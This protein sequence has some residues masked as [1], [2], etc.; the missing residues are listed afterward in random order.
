MKQMLSL[1]HVN[2]SNCIGCTRCMRICPTEAIR[3][4]KGKATL[5]IDKCIYCGRCFQTCQVNAIQ[6]NANQ[7]GDL[8]EGKYHIAILPIAIYGM[9]KSKEDLNV[10][11][12][13]LY[14]QGF[15]EVIELSP[16]YKVLSEK[17][18]SYIQQNHDYPIL[19]QCPTILKL[20][21]LN[22]G[23][24]VSKFYLLIFHMKEQHSMLS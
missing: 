1:L 12:H 22:H 8:E 24:L 11:Y 9:I 18:E 20:T 5:T 14:A 16:V 13:A 7:R 10:I 15:D 4:I 23:S 19:T 3:I 2:T 21:L 6:V 17:I